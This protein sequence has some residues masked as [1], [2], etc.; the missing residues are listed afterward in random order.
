MKRIF[1]VSLSLSV[2]EA[3]VSLH[4]VVALQTIA[5]HQFVCLSVVTNANLN[6][7]IYFRM[8][9]HRKWYMACLINGVQN[10]TLVH[11]EQDVRER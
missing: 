9:I 11:I 1:G 3:K 8:N 7:H 2:E 5:C 6:L 4:V 10:D